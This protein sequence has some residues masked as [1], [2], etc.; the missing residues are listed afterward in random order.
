MDHENQRGEEGINAGEHNLP[1][2]DPQVEDPRHVAAMTVVIRDMA[3]LSLR[4]ERDSTSCRRR[5]L[6]RYY[7][8][9]YYGHIATLARVEVDD[10]DND[11][12]KTDCSS[13]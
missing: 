10:D 3:E 5:W 2:A 1:P 13:I 6:P 9:L 12:E 8:L 4:H 7:Y 11:I